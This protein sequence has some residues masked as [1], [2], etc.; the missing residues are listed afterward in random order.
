MIPA[1]VEIFVAMVAV[2]MRCGFNRLSGHVRE[3]MGHEPDSGALYVFLGRNGH[4]AKVLFH[5]GTGL[6]LFYKRLDSRIFRIP[7]HVVHQSDIGHI[8]IPE[9]ALEELLDGVEKLKRK[10]SRA[11]E[12]VGQGAR[13][14]KSR[15]VH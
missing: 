14:S 15:K 10:S 2:D 8:Q 13:S 3:A 9:H 5:D 12:A 1:G 4:T 7:S 11:V 6:C